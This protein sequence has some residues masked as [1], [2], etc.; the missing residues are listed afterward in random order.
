MHT[1]IQD[2][3]NLINKKIRKFAEKLHELYPKIPVNIMLEI[4]CN[5]QDMPIL[6]EDESPKTCKHVLKKGRQYKT[7]LK[8]DVDYCSKHCKEL[9]I[10]D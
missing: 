10:D 2:I 7:K 3:T 6:D 4:W 1:L 8:G 9:D 5:Q